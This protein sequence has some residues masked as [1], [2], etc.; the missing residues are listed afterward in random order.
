MPKEKE[1]NIA[2]KN[3]NETPADRLNIVIRKYFT[4]QAELANLL[5]IDQGSL[6]SYISGK[7]KFTKKFALRL[8]DVAR[9]NSDYL[10][11][12]NLPMMIDETRKPILDDNIP[13]TSKTNTKTQHGIIKHYILEYEGSQQILRDTGDA[14]VINVVLG[15]LEE[16]IDPFMAKNILLELPS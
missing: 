16:K 15:N 9:I 2:D 10:L 3:I 6:S 5:E 13:Y 12:E 8:Q 11:N 1:K 4:T 7:N 14:S